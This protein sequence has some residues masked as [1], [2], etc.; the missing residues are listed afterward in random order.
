MLY[1]Y[2]GGSTGLRAPARHD[3]VELEQGDGGFE[4][5][6]ARDFEGG[7]LSEGNLL[8][9][10]LHEWW[11]LAGSHERRGQGVQWP[12][13]KRWSRAGRRGGQH[14]G[15]VVAQPPELLPELAHHRRDVPDHGLRVCQCK[16]Q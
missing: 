4:V 2:R 15:H 6:L 14:G 8:G 5:L 10:A 9:S 13:C 11:R 1:P 16:C 3:G 7:G 12:A